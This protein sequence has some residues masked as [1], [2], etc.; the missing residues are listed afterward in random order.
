MRLINHQHPAP[1]LRRRGAVY[2]VSHMPS[3]SE[4]RWCTRVTIA[5]WDLWRT[6]R[7]RDRFF[8]EYFT[9]SLPVAFHRCSIAWKYNLT[10]FL[11][12]FI[13]EL[14]NKPQGC[15]ASVASAAAPFST[16]NDKLYLNYNIAYMLTNAGWLSEA[17]I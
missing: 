9:F 6:K 11:F 7:H 10:I 12:I 16:K 1:T 14:H 4:A 17:T 15:G 8:P 13:T 5:L 3:Q 2:P